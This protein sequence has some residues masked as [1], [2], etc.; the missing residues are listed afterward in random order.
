MRNSEDLQEITE[1]NRFVLPLVD[2]YLLGVMVFSFMY[3]FVP[4]LQLSV[5]KLSVIP[6]LKP[7]SRKCVWEDVFELKSY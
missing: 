1:N 6:G 4:K 2:F 7:I 5:I 3:A